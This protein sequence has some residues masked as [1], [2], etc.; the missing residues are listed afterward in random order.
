MRRAEPAQR[1]AGWQN[2]RA[3]R[4]GCWSLW[5]FSAL[6]LLSLC[7]ELDRQRQA[8]ARLATT[9]SLYFPVFRD[10]PETDFGGFFETEAVY[11]DPEVQKLIEEKG[12]MVWPPIPYSYDTVDL[13]PAR[14]RRRRRRPGRTGSAPTTRRAT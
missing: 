12:W 2:F 11:T 14:A 13:R 1:G 10:Y 6:L 8:A 4:R 5:I 3:N 7:A 9:G